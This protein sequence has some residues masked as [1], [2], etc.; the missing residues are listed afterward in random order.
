VN[1][2]GIPYQ[3]VNLEKKVEELNRELKRLAERAQYLQETGRQISACRNVVELASVACQSIVE[4][5]DLAMAWVGLVRGDGYV[6]PISVF[7]ADLGEIRAPLPNCQMKAAQTGQSIFVLDTIENPPFDDCLHI[8]ARCG[9]QSCATFPILA[10]DRC[11][12]TFTISSHR[13]KSKSLILQAAPII[14]TLM[15]QVSVVWQRCLSEE[16]LHEREKRLSNISDNI[17]N[18]MTYQMIRE[19]DGTYHFTHVSSGVENLH[20]YTAEEVL[21]DPA[22]FYNQVLEEDL[23]RTMELQ[24]ESYRTG[25]TFK[26][27]IRMHTRDGRI[28]WRTLVSQPWQLEDG[29]TVWDGLELDVTE[30][31]HS[32]KALQ[33]SEEKFR[34]TFEN[35]HD[36]IIWA[37]TETGLIMNCNKASENFFER[38]REEIVNHHQTILHPQQK[39]ERYADLFKKHIAA[40]GAF[41]DEAEVITGSGTVKPVYISASIIPVAG[42]TI[43]QGIFRD[44]TE[45]KKYEEELS[46]A[47]DLAEA[48]NRA[49]ST[50][51]ANMSHEI[52]TPMNAILGYVQLMQRD[53][54]LTTIQNEYLDIINRSGEHLLALI[55]DILEISKIEDG[56]V[57]LHPAT[58]DLHTML[59]DLGAM[60]RVRTDAKGLGLAVE[61]IGEVPCMVRADEGKLRQVLINIIGNA[62]KFT[63]HGGISL[64]VKADQRPSG[65]IRIIIDIEDTGIGIAP[66]DH[67]KV[68]D[69]FEQTES[70]WRKGGG[71]GLGL[72]ISRQYTRM[73]GG[74]LI[75]IWSELG[76]GSVFR[77]EFNAEADG[78]AETSELAASLGR[79]QRIAPGEKPRRILVVDDQDTNRDLL[80]RMLLEVGFETREAVDG[81]EAIICNEQWRPDVILMDVKMPNMDGHE[82]TRRIKMS[83]EGAG[84]KIFLVTANAL[85]ENVTSSHRACADGFICKP[86]REEEIFE[87]IRCATGVEYVYKEK[88]D[89]RK[90][91]SDASSL[92]T[93]WSL[94]VFS[95]DMRADMIEALE[96]GD[97]ER[98]LKLIDHVAHCAPAVADALRQLAGRYE[99]DALMKLLVGRGKNCPL[100]N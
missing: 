92:L 40:K 53:P 17:P 25:S 79:V 33:E 21:A 11:V 36:A 68:F 4:Y 30:S 1:S 15:R 67:D 70:G 91:P 34:L 81:E 2:R 59:Y 89:G 97:M 37:D 85:E 3:A 83:P 98:L 82:A 27:E 49:K 100:S 78:A 50:F 57:E 72:P 8:A 77:F 88:G 73:M 46:K 87:A 66:E 14:E 24:E 90:N 18:G 54:A 86:F 16:A 84:V 13:S 74:D 55:N 52:R 63:E 48:A 10:G 99:Y 51:L 44:I 28:R 61:L 80:V 60:F 35:A 43:I 96:I 29:L 42:G 39:S 71:T 93:P 23:S 7:P 32:Y 47:K 31:R 9:F 94:S 20:G 76:K 69:Q 19:A 58:F 41:E 95:E 5:L 75:L 38:R 45:R 56:R 62:V 26:I 64:R 6:Q 22:L 65:T 12:A